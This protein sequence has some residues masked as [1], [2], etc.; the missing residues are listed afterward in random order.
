MTS[1]TSA[2][3]RIDAL[4]KQVNELTGR[5][6]A[7]EQL[8]RS[9]T[10]QIWTLFNTVNKMRES[11]SASAAPGKYE[12]MECTATH[13]ATGVKCKEV[14]EI[15]AKNLSYDGVQCPKCRCI[16][17]APALRHKALNAD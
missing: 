9:H 10:D 5:L 3:S 1:A 4:T 2:D 17:T 8:N 11:Q 15:C 14:F 16:Y 7:A 13:Y 12:K 6:E